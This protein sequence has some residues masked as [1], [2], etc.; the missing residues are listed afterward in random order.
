VVL[1]PTCAGVE[2]HVLRWASWLRSQG[3]VALVVDSFSAPGRAS[4][5]CRAKQNPHVRDV[6]AD[7]AGAVD[8]LRSQPFV[9][10]GRVGVVGFSYGANAALIA[11]HS[12]ERRFRAAIA[13]YPECGYGSLH[14][15]QI[16]ALLLVGG[17]D[18]ETPASV[19]VAEGESAQRKLVSWKVYPGV[20]HGFD[21]AELPSETRSG[22]RYDPRATADAEHEILKF[23]REHLSR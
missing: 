6:A 16:P 2:P 8:W 18:T 11:A 21:K 14:H 3:Y 10:A 13:F 23:F 19:C 5:V 9:A 17:A 7:A 12:G 4:N 20:T 15:V 22:Y 1:L